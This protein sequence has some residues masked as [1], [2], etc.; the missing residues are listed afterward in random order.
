MAKRRQRVAIIE[1]HKR[2]SGE[3]FAVTILLRNEEKWKVAPHELG[4]SAEEMMALKKAATRSSVIHMIGKLTEAG[5]SYEDA[6]ADVAKG[7]GLSAKSVGRYWHDWK[8]QNP[9]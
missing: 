1:E 8:R 5:M 3:C 7:L 4:P 2:E 6:R 9:Q